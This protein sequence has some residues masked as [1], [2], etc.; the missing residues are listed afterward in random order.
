M[1]TPV[2]FKAP[3]YPRH[4]YHI[5]FKSNDGIALFNTVEN[6]YFFL[7]RFSQFFH[8]YCHCL[9]YCLLDNHVH[10]IVQIKDL[11]VINEAIAA[12]EVS[13]RTS[14]MKKLLKDPGNEGL[15]DEVLERQSCS[16]MTSYTNAYNKVF[17]RQGSLFQTPFRRVAIE[18]DSHLQ[19]A[20]IYVHANAQKH[21]L[22]RDF[23]EYKY[24]SYS[25]VLNDNTI[26][27]QGAMVLEF[28]GGNEQFVKTHQMQ[29]DYYYNR[30]W[31]SSKLE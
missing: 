24:T 3:F 31:P 29:V 17:L 9:S 10:F 18:N 5:V 14:V 26:N 11:T 7:Q 25:E 1:P 2:Q 12:V 21:G 6:R 4:Y 13:K 16:F 19:Q 23:K 30:G 22:V 8:P 15:I 28:F 20:I 27:V